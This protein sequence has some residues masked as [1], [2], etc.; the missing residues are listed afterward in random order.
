ME[1]TR[2]LSFYSEVMC[3]GHGEESPRLVGPFSSSGSLDLSSWDNI[4]DSGE[5]F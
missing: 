3:E 1:G 5:A 4:L 2:V